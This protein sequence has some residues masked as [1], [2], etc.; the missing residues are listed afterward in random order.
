MEAYMTAAQQL[1]EKG[2]RAG[3]VEGK[4]EGN[5]DGKQESLRPLD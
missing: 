3:I 5:L 1:I 2:K 4:K